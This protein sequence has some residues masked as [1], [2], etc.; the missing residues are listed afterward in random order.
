MHIL[1][2]GATGVIG[3]RVVPKLVEAGHEVSASAR[4]E[5]KR[6]DV[7]RLG[8][9]PIEL[10]LFRTGSVRRAVT[11]QDVVINLATHIPA[12][13]LQMLLP[14]GWRENDRIRREGSRLLAEA[15]AGA[16]A[17]RLVQESFA[18]TYPDRGAD[19]I[20]ESVPLAPVKYNRTVA[21]AEGSAEWFARQG[22]T[23]V[24][25]RFG[26]FYGADARHVVDMLKAVEKGRAPLPGPSE[27]YLSSISHDDAAAAV[28]AS[29]TLPGG[30]YNVVDDEPITRRDYF[31]AMASALGVP[32]PRPL[33]Q[34]A[35]PLMGSLGELLA[36]SQRMSNR[37]LRNAAGFRP[38]YPSV[39]EGWPAVIA[40]MRRSGTLGE[41]TRPA[42]AA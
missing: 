6:L 13:T 21:D 31:A 40:E 28:L 3:R 42:K 30:P 4:S 15:A 1:V 22:G 41:A 9:K 5:G 2:T 14:W 12:S 11:G 37:K 33:P 35:V 29:L 18:P 16:G 20:D 7:G 38:I 19:W 32:A 10:D 26:G 39:R 17:G 34:W 8:A 24:V 23:A 25:L 27:A 36:R